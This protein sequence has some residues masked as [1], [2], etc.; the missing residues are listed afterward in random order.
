MKC[1]TYTMRK[2][3]DGKQCFVHARMCATPEYM[4][5][6]A[7]YLDVTGC[8]LFGGIYMSKSFDGGKTWTELEPQEGLMTTE[9]DGVIT[10]NCDATPMYHKKTGK[11][12]LL[13]HKVEYLVGAKD[14][15]KYEAQT[16][17]SVYN[18]E[19][20]SFSKRRFVELPDG[21][22]PSGN[23]SGQA[24]ELDNGDILVPLTVSMDENGHFRA[25]VM[26]CSFDGETV[27]FKEMSNLM[28]FHVARGLC[29]PSVVYHEGMYYL[30]M[31]NDEAAFVAKS[32]DGMHYEDMHLWAWEDGSLLQSYNTQ[33]HW[34]KVGGKL[35]LVYTRRDET[36]NH[37]F[38]HR[39]PLWMA[40]VKDM[41]LVKSTEI[42]VTPERGARM[43]NFGVISLDD[44]RA[45]TM[46]AEWMQ[47]IGCEKYGS[48]NS[49][50]V[51]VI[52]E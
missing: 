45:M 34:A 33:Q 52:E 25:G 40:E 47:P 10:G 19:S 50:F 26:R 27:T 17:Y 49:I 24:L 32:K 23:G 5:A 51:S 18:E 6:T 28:N 11:V 4:L 46:V 7:Q 2:G 21:V 48:D 20:N 36:N 22:P 29:E 8:D 1:T 3:Y 38:R 43:G 35:Y 9:K 41:R 15:G 14:P 39:A 44:G 42:R 12:L 16:F 30:T 31:R 13:G 37:V